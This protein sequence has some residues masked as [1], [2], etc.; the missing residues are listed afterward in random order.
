M[1]FQ[2]YWSRAYSRYPYYITLLAS[3]GVGDDDVQMDIWKRTGYITYPQNSCESRAPPGPPR[4]RDRSKSH[5][6][7]V[8]PSRS[9]AKERAS[10]PNSASDD[11]FK[12]P[13]WR[14][15]VITTFPFGSAVV[16]L[17]SGQ[18]EPQFKSPCLCFFAFFLFLFSAVREFK[19]PCLC[20]FA[21]SF[22][23]LYCCTAVVLL[24]YTH[25]GFVGWLM[26]FSA[27]CC[28][29]LLYNVLLYILL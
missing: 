11:F 7:S 25:G 9:P 13:S 5:P 23:L 2:R 4:P 12:L 27:V 10:Q 19:S 3:G 24:L 26:G 14:R 21:F 16:A 28:A 18:A 1:G 20:F 8:Q 15:Q 29:S 22:F 6:H 17:E